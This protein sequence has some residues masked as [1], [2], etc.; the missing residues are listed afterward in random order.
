MRIA[1]VDVCLDPGY[2]VLICTHIIINYLSI[3]VISLTH[4]HLEHKTIS[5]QYDIIP[6]SIGTVHPSVCRHRASL[7]L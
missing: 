2:L 6:Q 7:S 3:N 1:S 4:F 5:T